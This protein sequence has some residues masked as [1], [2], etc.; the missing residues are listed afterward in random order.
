MPADTPRRRALRRSIV[1]G[2]LYAGLVGLGEF[3]LVA[4][5]VRQGAGPW[6]LATLV[7]V[8]QLVGAVGALA[9]VRGLRHLPSRRPLTTAAVVGQALAFGALALATILG[10]SGPATLIV[11]S[12]T[13][14]AFARAAGTAWSSWYGDVV[15]ARIRGRWFGRRNRWVSAVTFAG[16]VVGGLVLWALEPRGGASSGGGGTG[17]ALLYAAAALSRLG[18]APLLWSSWEPPFAPPQAD[19]RVRDELS[20]PEGAAGRGV[21]VLGAALLAAVS[22][23][24]PFFAPHML[25]TLGFS[26]PVYLASQGLQVAAKVLS[27]GVWGRLVDA[28]GPA[29][30]YVWTAVTIALIPIPWAVAGT[31]D[32]TWLVF[33]AQAVSGAAWG[34]NEVA[35]LALTLAA[36]S[37]RRR[38]VLF[39]VQAV[40]NGAAQVAGG[41]LGSGL[42]SMVDGAHAPMFLASA[43]ARMGVVLAAPALLAPLARTHP[44]M[45]SVA[46]RVVGWRPG[47]GVVREPAD[48]E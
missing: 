48:I 5:A 27:L 11:A 44:S 32:L 4:D 42:A 17:Y 31:S 46:A 13:Q 41:L 29:T 43:V 7:T 8:P 45:A 34:G 28:R 33:A 18:C 26:Y 24:T 15:P 36:R 6:A 35:T 38:A 3:W 19:D 22:L 39:A 30:V 37:G 10:R 9:A 40:A 20:G 25:R 23:A 21:V 16:I 1:E 2:V 14:Q 12:C 47:R